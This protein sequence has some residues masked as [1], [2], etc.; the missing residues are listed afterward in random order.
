M[1]KHRHHRGV[2]HI[3]V[4]LLLMVFVGFV[5]LA[6]DTL[7]VA[8]T[9]QQLQ[10][11]ADA[12]ALAGAQFVRIDQDDARLAAVEIALANSAGGGSVE[13]LPD[14]DV[15]I[16]RY[17]RETGT[18]EPTDTTPNAV[19]VTARRDSGSAAGPLALLFGPAFGVDT[20]NVARTAI[21]MS[22]SPYNPALIVLHPTASSALN[23]HGNPELV[24]TGGGGVHVNSLSSTAVD[25]G[26]TKA[27]IRAERV[28]VTG[29]VTARSRPRISGQLNVGVAPIVDPLLTLPEPLWLSMP[30]RGTVSSGSTNLTLQPGYYPGG[31][32]L[33]QS[34]RVVMSPGVYALDGVGLR[35]NNSARLTGNGVMLYILDTTPA[36]G[37][38]S[39][40]VLQS[41]GT[42]QLTAPT[43]GVY[44]GVG[45]FQS[46]TNTNTATLKADASLLGGTYYF[47][48]N[49]V[50][51][52]ANS[53]VFGSRMIVKTMAMGGSGAVT[54]D[55]ASFGAT[56]V[57][58]V[59]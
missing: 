48:S 26:G 22:Q 7:F 27:F 36:N 34:A 54:I 9:A 16:G 44:A 33:T 19:R 43:S 4:A 20:A 45:L 53:G 24:L 21:A 35:V 52:S 37:T 32:T 18:F 42:L 47:P 56:E 1:N 12:A 41:T 6:I 17:D 13:L 8:L 57:Y 14:E 5:G 3:W 49:H 51:L 59:E 15:T 39:C 11:A 40:L 23:L 29:N 55:Y 10:V 30:N 58:L 25:V 2:V 50:D 46:R 31:I 38:L 28:D